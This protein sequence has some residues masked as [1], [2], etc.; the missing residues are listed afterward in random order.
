M[1]LNKKIDVWLEKLNGLQPVIS[2]VEPD[3]SW[4]NSGLVDKT[5]KRICDS[6]ESDMQALESEAL[7]LFST[8]TE[9]ENLTQQSADVLKKWHIAGAPSLT[10]L[11][12]FALENFEI[13]APEDFIQG[14]L[15]SSILGEVEND[16]SYHN[17]MHYRKVLFNVIRMLS[18]H[19]FIYE[20]TA[21]SFD[22]QQICLMLMG[23]CAHDLGH[24]GLGNTVKGVFSQGRL[25]KLSYDLALPYFNAVGFADEKALTDF[26]V[27]LLCTEVTPLDDPGNP[28]NQMKAAYR[29]HYLGD[30][31]KTH[32]LNLDADLVELE[33]NPHL[34]MACLILH[35]A[36]IATSA[37]LTYEITKFETSIYMQEIGTKQARPQH[38]IDFINQICQ[39]QFLS[40]AGQRLY[41]ANLARIYA[42]AEQDVEDGDDIFPAPEHADF[43]LPHSGE[44]A[45]KTIN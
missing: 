40:D 33:T 10:A 26:R 18:I 39:R 11:C 7:F 21:R 3:K 38:I 45:P 20:G 37:G 6:F 12:V 31:T 14:V 13:E 35:E 41:A 23:A 34:T 24:D 8:Q 43:V 22:V 1:N 28:M 32:T 30:K 5:R 16:L 17:N 2:K 19:N 15:V 29:F 25:E 44:N 42:R 9:S 27:M 36:D 4:K